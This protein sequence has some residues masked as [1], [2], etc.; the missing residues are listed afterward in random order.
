MKDSKTP[1]NG[2]LDKTDK[3]KETVTSVNNS[4]GAENSGKK[5]KKKKMKS[6]L[7]VS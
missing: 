3:E 6:E 7:K 2:T 5:R 4:D 1:C